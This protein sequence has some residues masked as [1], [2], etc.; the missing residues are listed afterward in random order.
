MKKK[1]KPYLLALIPFLLLVFMFEL[2]PLFSIITKSFLSSDEGTFTFENYI[3]IL[4]RPFYQQA[5]W[6]SIKISLI[7][8]IIGIIIA[9]FGAK[10]VHNSDGK[11]KRIF[12]SILN[13][14]SNFAGVPLA[15]AFIILLGKTGIFV[16]LGKK[17]GIDVLANFDL[18]SMKGLTLIYVYFQIP[19]A[20]LLL[21]PAFDA[22]RE[23]WKEAAKILRANTFQFWRYVGLPII[24]PSILGTLSVLFSNALVAYATAYALLV[25]NASIIPI[26]IS[27]LFVG[28]IMQ[29]PE[30]GSALSII[31]MILMIIAFAINN[32]LTKRLRKDVE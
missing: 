12:M 20:T 17:L 22:I 14:T 5:I 15:F 4:S 19:L 28:D 24:F 10:A 29:R 30:L 18:Y 3:T 2:M 21:I 8:S 32:I 23:E 11:M 16:I 13:M 9:F 25:G 7:S 6:N 26:R 27:E 31:L 1:L